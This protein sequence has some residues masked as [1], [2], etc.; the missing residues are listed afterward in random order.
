[1][2]KLRELTAKMEVDLRAMLG[3]QNV[4]VIRVMDRDT[5]DRWIYDPRFRKDGLPW[6]VT[7]D[8][9]VPPVETDG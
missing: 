5:L 8:L 2:A 1:M 4:P 3:L 9:A 7:G 6:D